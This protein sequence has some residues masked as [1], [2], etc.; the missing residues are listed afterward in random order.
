MK[1]TLS[2]CVLLLLLFSCKTEKSLDELYNVQKIYA[3]QVLKKVAKEN[4]NAIGIMTSYSNFSYL[5]SYTKDGIEIHLVK[6]TNTK[7]K[8]HTVN[9]Y[10][11]NNIISENVFCLDSIQTA[12]DEIRKR[13]PYHLDGDYLII[14]YKQNGKLKKEIIPVQIKELRYGSFNS[15]LLNQISK[16]IQEHGIWDFSGFK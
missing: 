10:A 8:Q 6:V 7:G 16:D 1:R 9:M 11:Q 12:N 13:F 3:E 14:Q 5:T 15:I 4:G 2:K